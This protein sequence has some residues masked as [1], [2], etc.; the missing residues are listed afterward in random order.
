M[1]SK[2]RIT[3]PDSPKQ[4]ISPKTL[5]EIIALSARLI[6][7]NE[8]QRVVLE[9]KRVSKWRDACNRAFQEKWQSQATG[10]DVIYALVRE[11]RGAEALRTLRG[12]L[13]KHL[14][15]DE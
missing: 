10:F 5:N 12:V 3:D 1:K 2:K 14:G 13:R 11:K 8:A 6:A 7:E 4:T 15:P 9:A